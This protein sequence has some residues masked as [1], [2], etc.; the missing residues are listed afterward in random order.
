LSEFIQASF[1][2]RGIKSNAIFD[3]SHSGNRDNCFQPFWFVREKLKT[4]C[5]EINTP[6]VNGGRETAFD[7]QL[8]VQGEKEGDSGI[9]YLLMLETPQVSPDNGISTHWDR[10]RK[11]LTW[12][13]ELVDGKKFIK[14]NFPNIIQVHPEDGFKLR[15]RFCCLISSNKAL[16]QNDE[17]DLYPKRVEVIRWFERNAHQDFDLYGLGWDV[18]AIKGGLK[19]RI[20]NRFWRA[21][22]RIKP[23]QPFP[24]YRGRVSRKSDVLSRTR[25]AICY[26]NVR[27]LPGYITEKIFDC[28]FSGCIPVYWG[29]SNITDYIPADCFIDRRKFRDTADVY[30]ALKNISEFEFRGYQQ[31]I[32]AFLQSDAAYPFSSEF[33]AET[34]VSTIVRDIGNQS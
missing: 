15:D 24:S 25:F 14:I 32:A 22:C 16:A 20:E 7:L 23:M 9:R 21:F 4:H 33:F 26:E 30:M 6:D 3:L 19:G 10:Y 18:P 1:S 17:R 29:A 28:F 13:D 8:D 5:I 2:A 27:D 11:I 31:R 34:I 12:N